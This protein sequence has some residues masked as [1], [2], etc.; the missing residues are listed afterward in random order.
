M[1]SP[2]FSKSLNIRGASVMDAM[3]AALLCCEIRHEDVSRM[4]GGRHVTV[5]I[6]R[7]I[8]FVCFWSFVCCSE[9]RWR[10][11]SQPRVLVFQI[12]GAYQSG[13]I[14]M[15]SVTVPSVYRTSVYSLLKCIEFLM[16][17]T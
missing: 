6:A 14:A 2:N 17:V 11:K 8:Y 3:L 1:E 13:L 16:Y 10:G 4:Q 5:A 12:W 7:F 15:D 9:I